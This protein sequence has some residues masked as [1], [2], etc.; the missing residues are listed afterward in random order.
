M[1]LLELAALGGGITFGLGLLVM[2]GLFLRRRSSSP[3]EAEVTPLAGEVVGQDVRT[4]MDELDRMAGQIDIR[5]NAGLQKLDESIGIAEEKIAA[6]NDQSRQVEGA[7]QPV[8]DPATN[9]ILRMNRQGLDSIEIAR[10]MD[11]D[12]GE[13]ELIINLNLAQ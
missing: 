6:L 1:S 5:L 9:E 2:L 10:R 7:Y 3:D 13:V 11:M 12:V 4:L 8:E